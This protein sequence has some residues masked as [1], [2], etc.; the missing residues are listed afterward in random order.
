MSANNLLK[1][2]VD[3][4]EI[5][6]TNTLAITSIIEVLIEKKIITKKELSD[7]VKELKMISNIDTENFIN[8]EY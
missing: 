7:K 1:H 2:L 5:D 8:K 3:M 6:Y 4:K